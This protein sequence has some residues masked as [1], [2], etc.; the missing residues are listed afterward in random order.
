YTITPGGYISNNYAI[1]FFSGEL[2]IQQRT[3]TLTNFV[4]NDKTY[5]G[6]PS[7]TGTGFTPVNVISG[8]VLS[9][10]YDAAFT[11]SNVGLARTVSFTN[12]ALVAGGVNDN[13]HLQTTSGEATAAI[14]A[15]LIS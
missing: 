9:F 7:A 15:L 10:T 6:G 11:D 2:T 4:A 8:D 13:Y 12:I 3:I 14:N 1:E 5:N